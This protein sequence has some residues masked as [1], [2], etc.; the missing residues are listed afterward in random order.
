MAIEMKTLSIGFL[1]FLALVVSVAALA[2]EFGNPPPVKEITSGQPKDVVALIE[3]IAQ[4]NHWSDE[5]PYDKER[6]EWI[7][8][9]VERA[10]CGSLGSDEQ[11]LERKYKGNKKVLEAIA[12]AKE[13]VL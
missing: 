9:A 8:K 13:L 3:R 4:C 2:N 1:C 10:R 12:K 7:K 6:A 11:A 5:E